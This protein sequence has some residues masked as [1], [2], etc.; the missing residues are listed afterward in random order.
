MLHEK[1]TQYASSEIKEQACMPSFQ[2]KSIKN[3][4]VLAFWWF[5]IATFQKTFA[6]TVKHLQTAT[7]T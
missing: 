3:K 2:T 5:K 7:I 1:A 6:L 4:V